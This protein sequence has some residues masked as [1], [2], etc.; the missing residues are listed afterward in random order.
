MAGAPQADGGEGRAR[1]LAVFGT[2]PEAIKMAPVIAALRESDRISVRVAVTGQHRTMLDQVLTAF[3]IAPDIDLDLM[4]ENQSLDATAGRIVTGFGKVLER[5]RPDRVLVHGDTL[6]STMASLAAMLHRV[7]VAHVE[8]GLRSGDM[9]SPWPEEALR[10]MTGVLADLHFAPTKAAAA[11]LRA[12]N[13]AEDTITV[14]GNTVIGA[15]L[16]ARSR[17][18]ADPALAPLASELGARFAGKRLI[19]VTAHRRESFGPGF[20]AVA[21]AL[22]RLATREDVG[23]VFPLHPNPQVAR[24]MR[25]ALSRIENVALTQPLDYH[26]FV[27]LLDR[28]T[29]VLTDSGGVQEEAPSLDTPVLV[30][31]ETTER[32]EGIEAGTAKLVGTDEDAILAAANLLLDD[33]AAHAAMASARNPFGDGQAAARIAKVLEARHSP[34]A[35]S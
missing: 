34:D 5:E 16:W 33:A 7:P 2:R 25:P 24:I 15:L 12:E 30:M 29:L 17:I 20:E 35:N 28:A 13:V 19:V 14:T 22:R 8:A 23:I 31:R 9:Q 3:D 6:S 27:A 1:I 10:R 4:E 32:P 11:A 21:R 18:A 26:D